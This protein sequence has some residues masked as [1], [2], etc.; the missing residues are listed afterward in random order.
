MT[1]SNL[2]SLRGSDPQTRQQPPHPSSLPI[3]TATTP[4]SSPLALSLVAL[5]ARAAAKRGSDLLLTEAGVER[6]RIDTASFSRLV[7]TTA[8]RLVEWGVRPRTAVSVQMAPGIAQAALQ[9]GVMAVGAAVVPLGR[10]AR[11]RAW[12]P[13]AD[14]RRLI[15]DD[16]HADHRQGD[17]RVLAASEILGDADGPS[18]PIHAAARALTASHVARLRPVLSLT[19]SRRIASDSHAALLAQAIKDVRAADSPM[20]PRRRRDA[21]HHAVHVAL[22]TG[23][24]H[25]F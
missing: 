5:L 21:C 12:L 6:L 16:Q 25:H 10:T 11:P 18:L 23:E 13:L 17:I 20:P 14:C 2:S 15:V 9:V 3:L 8:F 22:L 7:E 4:S 19:G 24:P 1:S